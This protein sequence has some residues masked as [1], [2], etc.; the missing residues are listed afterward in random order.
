MRRQEFAT[1]CAAPRR[2]LLAATAGLGAASEGT[3]PARP[4][5]A[6]AAA[7]AA[8]ARPFAAAAATAAARAASAPSRIARQLRQLADR[9]AAPRCP[10]R[11][12]Q[13]PRSGARVDDDRK[14]V[15][16]RSS[17]RSTRRAAAASGRAAA[18]AAVGRAVPRAEAAPAAAASGRRQARPA[19]RR[20]QPIPS[21][22][23]RPRARSRLQPSARRSADA[24]AKPSRGLPVVSRWRRRILPRLPVL[25]LRLPYYGYP[26]TGV[27]I[28]FGL[29]YFYDPFGYGLGFGYGYGY[30]Y[31]Y[32]TAT[33]MAATTA[34]ATAPAATAGRRQQLVR[35]RDTGVA[36]AE[37]QAARGAGL[38]RRL[39]RR[40]RRQLRRRV[41]EAGHRRRRPPRRAQG[42]R[43]RAAAVRR[44][45]HAGRN[46]HLQGRDEADPVIRTGPRYNAA[47]CSLPSRC[48]SGLYDFVVGAFLLA[49]RR[50]A[51]VAL[52][53]AAR[54]RRGSSPT[55]TAVPVPSA[56][57]Y[58]LPWRDPERY[59][60]YLWVMGPLLKG[61]GAARVPARLRLPGSPRVVPA[62]RGERR[63]AGAAHAVGA[64]QERQRE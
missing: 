58:Y 7:E 34:T 30:G 14:R 45:D 63:R 9:S 28:R 48:I 21:D 62:V 8:A 49:G 64:A 3:L 24:R 11:P 59:R 60:G 57:G 4:S 43:L 17:R 25:R 35:P 56:I 55:S 16:G 31:G 47:R 29:G 37:D 20:A 44:A 39:L 38:R 13:R 22:R 26:A 10:A 23:W 51:R 61:A 27:R 54:A 52:R 12:S 15:R 41:P 2:W 19:R 5:R 32:A 50:T 40:R 33:A 46:G 36:A 1:R 53:R 42:G 18:A 6:V